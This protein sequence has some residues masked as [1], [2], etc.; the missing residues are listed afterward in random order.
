MGQF[1]I[2]VDEYTEP[3]QQ[4]KYKKSEILNTS[5][6]D[7]ECYKINFEDGSSITASNNHPFLARLHNAKAGNSKWIKTKDLTD[8][9]AVCKPLNV[10]DKSNTF[11]EG[12]LS[13]MFDG[14]GHVHKSGK[15]TDVQISQAP[16][17]LFDRIKHT[18]DSMGIP[19]THRIRQ[20]KD[21]K[22]P[23]GI[24]EVAVRKYSMEL[25]GRLRPERLL[26]NSERLWDGMAF[27]GRSFKN[28]FIKIK[29]IEYIGF[30]DTVG[31]TTTS[32]T[33]VSEGFISHNTD[34]IVRMKLCGLY[35]GE[36]W[37]QFKVQTNEVENAKSLKLGLVINME[38]CKQYM[39]RKWG[40]YS[41]I[42]DSYKYPF[43]NPNNSLDYFERKTPE[44]LREEY[45]YNA[46]NNA[47]RIYLD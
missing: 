29:S 15:G 4:R 5:R 43:N 35:D 44:Q 40:T 1:I 31:L 47:Y 14:E 30:Q 17:P 19:F 45:G 18:L 24:I 41:W 9:H 46:P 34:Y 16:G 11:D 21:H 28:Q 39:F 2:G 26:K 27:R 6:K 38:A 37:R 32:S 36:G 20:Q 8:S 33:L 7:R 42:G 13:G 22:N 25:L 10:W 3:N 23:I 12:W